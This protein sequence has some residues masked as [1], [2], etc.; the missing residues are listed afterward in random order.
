MT[1]SA[2]P[3][4]F[5]PGCGPDA[6]PVAALDRADQLRDDTDA[7]TALWAQARV[8]LLD[9]AGAL[10]DEAGQPLA[11]TGAQVSDGPGGVGA[12]AFLGLDD[13][14]RGW[15]ALDAAL[16]AVTSPHSVDLRTAAATWPARESAAFAEARALR[17]WRQ[18]HRFCGTCGGEVAML[19]A[20]WLGRCQSCGLDHY[21]RTDPAVI[22][23]VSDGARLL[24]G[25]QAA[26]PARRYSV[27]AGFVEPGES[28]E[29]AVAREVL[30]E[31]GL[32]VRRC[33]YLASQPWPFPAA[34][35]LGFAA[36]AEPGELRIGAELEDARW[37]DAAQIRDAI[38]REAAPAG[39]D[40]GPLLSSPISISRWLVERWLD[41]Q[42][43]A[44]AGAGAA[45]SS[46]HDAQGGHG[47][48][49]IGPAR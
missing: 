36:E 19:R 29:Q 49:L 45:V 14:G 43:L 16:T 17:S 27:I 28:L 12:A 2:A 37:F 25:R 11:L 8:L 3:F 31:T 44:M 22:V 30:E 40:D 47:Q 48:G 32:Q 26:W 21:P 1:S 38:A 6:V 13:T 5:I 46:D 20:G 39:D 23:A 10:C 15:F 4:A 9:D 42:S 41:D 18:R 33:R 34:L 24:L 35:M 7:L